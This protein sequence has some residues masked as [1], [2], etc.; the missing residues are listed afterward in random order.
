VPAS[1]PLTSRFFSI[2]DRAMVGI[3]Y[4]SAHGSILEA[5][6][7]FC[8]ML[9]YTGAELHRLTTRELTHPDDRDRHEQLTLELV[10]NQ[11]STINDEQRFV[12]KSGEVFWSKR[13]ASRVEEPSSSP[14]PHLIEVVEDITARMEFE[15]R[16]RETFDHASVGIMHSSLDR[17]VLMINRKFCDMVGYSAD[18]LQHGSVRRIHHPEDTD[19]D[20]HLEKRLVAGEIDSFSFEK[21]YVRKDGSVFWAHRTVSLARDEVGK[22][23]YFI[24]VIEDISARKQ[25]EQ[26]LIQL[27][28]YDVLTSLP[29]RALFRDRLR[30][31]LAQAHRSR[32]FLAIMFVDLDRFKMINDSLGH[33]M[34]DLLLKQVAH[35]L[36]ACVRA[37]DT[38]GR[39][40]GDEFGVLLGS[41]HGPSDANSVAQKILQTCSKPFRLDDHERHVTTSIGISLYPTDGQEEDALIK[42]ADSAMYRAKQSGRNGFHFFNDAIDLQSTR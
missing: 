14:Q 5:N 25:A 20:Q 23:K 12:R 39:L 7:K 6:R 2:F 21:R 15:Q 4:T 13:M 41:L 27:A 36:T 24:R 28:H 11:R 16:F 10:S 30:Q 1:D 38:V 19:A 26:E 8:E 32:G 37:S 35:R 42:A 34:G 29:N 31:A 18:E 9:G 33:A 17:R 22:P 40:G 3:A